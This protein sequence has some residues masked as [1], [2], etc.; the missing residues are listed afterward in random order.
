[1]SDGAK[2]K[3]PKAPAE[4]P[5]YA[6]MINTAILTLKDR[7]GSSRQSIEKYIKANYKVGDAAGQH[8]KR[9]LKKGVADGKIIN[10]KGVGASGS[11]KLP[12]EQKK[13]SKK[14]AA[15]AK[16]PAATKKTVTKSLAA[17]KNTS[18]K[19]AAK[20]PSSKKGGSKTPA[21][22][23]PSVKK[24]TSKPK[25]VAA[26]KPTTKKTLKKTAVAKKK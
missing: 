16:K 7:N 5:K 15:P 8:I 24:S 11:F 12:K 18:P 25:E 17:K 4:H 2:R 22:K 6:E 23:K 1:M 20:S 3:M 13:P 9:V 14:P 21:A 10:T 26:K 19:K